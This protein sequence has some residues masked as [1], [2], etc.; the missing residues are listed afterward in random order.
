[1]IQE[2]IRK[3][4][5]QQSKVK[6][7]SPQWMVAE[8]LIDLVRAEPRCAEILAQDLEVEAMSIT[9]AE[10]KIK[11]YA[12]GHK[13]GNFACVMP[14]EA[15]RILREFYGLP[16]RG[17]VEAGVIGLDLADFLG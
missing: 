17:A 9:E 12:D 11:A 7:R 2:A 8:Q 4:R 15:D 10:K 14:G 16:E 5:E 3:L 6:E 13:T 1:M